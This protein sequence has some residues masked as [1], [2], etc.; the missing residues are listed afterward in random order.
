[1]PYYSDDSVTIYHGDCREV[2]PT[3]GDF[4][5]IL[6]DPPYGLNKS[7]GASKAW[8]GNCGKGR[9]WNGTPEWDK[10]AA[11]LGFLPLAKNAIVWGGN[12]FAELPAKKGW[13]VW[14]KQAAMTQAQA[15]LAWTNFVST[16]RVFRLSPLS[17]FGKGHINGEIKEHPTQKPLALFRWCLSFAPDAEV[18]VDPFAGSGTTGVACKLE[19][20]K[21]VLIEISEEYCE[22]AADR[23]RQGVLF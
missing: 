23:L 2:L 9:L 13:L 3:L 1:M 18:V 5:L 22:K 20:R 7:W 19:G 12:Y 6:T 21:A 15:E 17:V 14:D 10:E 16:V 11:E 8:Q 4:D